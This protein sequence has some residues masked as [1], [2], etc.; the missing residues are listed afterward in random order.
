MK[1]YAFFVLLTMMWLCG[2]A[3]EENTGIF[4]KP[5]K[6]LSAEG[7]TPSLDSMPIMR[8]SI[9]TLTNRID[10]AEASGMILQ[11][12]LDSIDVQLQNLRQAF[13]DTLF[14]SFG[15]RVHYNE[16]FY[17]RLLMESS[18]F[19]RYSEYNVDF[20]L[21]AADALGYSREEHEWYNL[22]ILY[23]DLLRNYD[24]YTQELVKLIDNI[25]ASFDTGN[26]Y[27]D[28]EYAL[29][30]SK[31]KKMHYQQVRGRDPNYPSM[32]HIAYLDLQVANLRE[33]FSDERKFRVEKFKQIR[34][35]LTGE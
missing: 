23:A 20:T 2:T 33:C 14:S 18:L 30:E 17:V 25:L 32:K 5:K 8:D 10:S 27:R 11:H 7:S 19:M 16:A 34:K 12:R 28:L 3:Q 29:F 24:L 31:L 6:I 35:Y 21:R 4:G 9:V 13:A 15:P 22:Y 1:R 26:V